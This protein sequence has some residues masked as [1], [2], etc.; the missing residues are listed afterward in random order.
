MWRE[1]YIMAYGDAFWMI[2]VWLVSSELERQRAA[3]SPA[4]DDAPP[5]LIQPDA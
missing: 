5:C 4:G 3:S 1:A 2:A